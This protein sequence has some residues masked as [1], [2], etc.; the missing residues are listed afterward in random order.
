MKK[1]KLLICITAAALVITSISM[2]AIM[3]NYDWAVYFCW[4]WG[5]A[6]LWLIIYIWANSPVFKKKPK[7]KKKK[8]SDGKYYT[9][10]F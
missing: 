5:L 10:R 2:L 7:Q 3:I 9:R 4:P 6:Q 8:E 1:S